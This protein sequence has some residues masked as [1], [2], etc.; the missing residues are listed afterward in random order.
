MCACL[1]NVRF[2]REEELRKRAYAHINHVDDVDPNWIHVMN[3]V[4]LTKNDTEFAKKITVDVLKEFHMQ[5]LQRNL[6]FESESS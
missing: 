5:N 1:L 2:L 3:N 6:E 4:V